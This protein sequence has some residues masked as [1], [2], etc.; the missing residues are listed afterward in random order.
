MKNLGIILATFVFLIIGIAF[1]R[2]IGDSV[3]ATSVTDSVANETFLGLNNTNADLDQENIIPNSE[4]VLNDTSTQVQP[5]G[6]YTMDYVR[7]YIRLINN[8]YNNTNMNISYNYYPSTYVRGT[9]PRALISL[10][11]LFFALAVT[12]IA[13]IGLFR[14][15]KGN[16]FE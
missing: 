10:V 4:V 12:A 2:E 8:A 1:L 7:G 15:G 11:V 9:T 16:V 14:L 13:I 5:G 3:A 6:N